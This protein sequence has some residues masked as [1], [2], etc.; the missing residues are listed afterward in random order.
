[1]G[2]EAI[3]KSKHRR[4]RARLLAAGALLLVAPWLVAATVLHS[5]QEALGLAFPDATVLEHRAIPLD[6][7]LRSR[8][9]ARLG[10][11]TRDHLIV[12]HEAFRDGALVGR[13]VVIEEV[14]K[15]LPFRFLVSVRPDGS[16]DQVLLLTYRESRGGEIGRE[17]FRAQYD[18]KTLSDPIHRG[19]DIRNVSGATLSVDSLSRGV[20]RALALVDVLTETSVAATAGGV[21]VP[22]VG[23]GGGGGGH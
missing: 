20:R 3:A 5:D 6:A 21:G 23:A 8:L 12:L 22:G 17:S 14:G 2:S 16:V 10:R 11:P 19:E 4:R 7:V 15:T 13:A 1:M 9:E 18:G